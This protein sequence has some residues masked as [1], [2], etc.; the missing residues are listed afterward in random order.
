IE[1]P[2]PFPS[3]NDGQDWSFS[4]PSFSLERG[5]KPSRI[6]PCLGP[7][8]RSGWGAKPAPRALRSS[9]RRQRGPGAGPAA[10]GRRR[11]GAPRRAAAAASVAGA[12]TTGRISGAATDEQKGVLPGV[13]VEARGPAL[14][15][16]RTTTTDDRGDYRLTLLPPGQYEVTFTL[17]G[18]ASETRTGVTGGLARD[19]TLDA[20]MRPAVEESVFVSGA[21]P[22]G[23]VS[24]AAGG[25]NPA[26]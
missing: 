10:G 16:E 3:R 17:Q 8:L 15:G 7:C 2:P 14:Q 21:V 1:Y 5:T 12:Q 11:G 23:N 24:S 26:A 9:L 13:T 20:G 22:P 4:Q 19:T 25:P 18:F 6:G